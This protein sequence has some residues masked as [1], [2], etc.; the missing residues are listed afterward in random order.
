MLFNITLAGVC[1]M[2]ISQI[3][4]KPDPLCLPSVHFCVGKLVTSALGMPQPLQTTSGQAILGKI[5]V[6]WP[7]AGAGAYCGL[8][9]GG[10]LTMKGEVEK[11]LPS[12]LVYEG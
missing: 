7:T 4:L 10:F 11:V 9:T 1:G 2:Y 12:G 5:A 8:L 3:K 6:G